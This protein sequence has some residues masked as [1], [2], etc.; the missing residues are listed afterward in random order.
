LRAIRSSRAGK[1]A[2][3]VDGAIDD[4]VLLNGC[5]IAFDAHPLRTPVGGVVL[6]KIAP[7]LIRHFGPV[8]RIP[9][10]KSANN[11]ALVSSAHAHH[12]GESL[13]IQND[14]HG[15]S[16][17]GCMPKRFHLHETGLTAPC[18]LRF[19]LPTRSANVLPDSTGHPRSTKEHGDYQQATNTWPGL[20]R[21]KIGEMLPP[22]RVVGDA[23]SLKVPLV[24]CHPSLRKLQR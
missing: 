10:T 22:L 17:L 20:V 4:W 19:G 9:G 21:G 7:Q 6:T 24:S 11:V 12:A 14:L 1:G 13:P 16:P 3:S 18:P 23:S 15:C 5:K 8:T 2:F